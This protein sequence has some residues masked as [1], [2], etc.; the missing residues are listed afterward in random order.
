MSAWYAQKPLYL[1]TSQTTPHCKILT[2]AITDIHNRKPLYILTPVWIK[3]TSAKTV[4]L[5]IIVFPNITLGTT[6]FWMVFNV[7]SRFLC[8][9]FQNILGQSTTIKA[10]KVCALIEASRHQSLTQDSQVHYQGNSCA[11]CG[12]WG[13]TST[14]F[15]RRSSDFYHCYSTSDPYSITHHWCYIFLALKALSNN[16]LKE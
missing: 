11:I 3:Y 4:W 15:Y 5:F 9:F 1:R 13:G 8:R 14:G 2:T 6:V 7:V 16:I 10:V 12:S